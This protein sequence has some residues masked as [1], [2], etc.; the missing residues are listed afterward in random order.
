[1]RSSRSD[2]DASSTASVPLAVVVPAPPPGGRLE[3][4]PVVERPDAG[5]RERLGLLAHHDHARAADR[6][7]QPAGRVEERAEV[8]LVARRRARA[9]S[10]SSCGATA[11]ARA[12]AS[13]RWSAAASCR[14]GGR[15]RPRRRPARPAG[16]GSRRPGGSSG[17]AGG[18]RPSQCALVRDAVGG[19]RA[20]AAD[21]AGDGD[22]REHVRAAPGTASPSTARTPAAAGRARSRSRTAAP[23]RA[24][25]PA[26]TCR[27]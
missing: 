27:R 18:E 9:G 23:P 2:V 3:R 13:R 20:R 14:C 21:E 16:A 22:Q 1:M 11:R 5:A 6:V 19:R 12:A 4:R 17:R 10:S 24:R 26:S 15:A 25:R 8:E 7:G